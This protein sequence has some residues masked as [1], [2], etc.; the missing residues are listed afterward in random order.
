[1][2][3]FVQL[4]PPSLNG[5]RNR[6]N[7]RVNDV[8]SRLTP[9]PALHEYVDAHKLA[10]MNR[11]ELL[12]L[13]LLA[14]AKKPLYGLELVEQSGGKLKRGLIY[15]TL[16]RLE[17]SGHVTSKPEEVF[18]YQPL[19]S[20]ITIPRRLYQI[21]SSGRRATLPRAQETALPPLGKQ[22]LQTR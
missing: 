8:L 11:K 21:T 10:P 5:N 9:S 14:R 13:E 19:G 12:I 20:P 7:E 18:S 3:A 4:V 16:N 6:G 2:G 1:M 22:R 17:E 15:V